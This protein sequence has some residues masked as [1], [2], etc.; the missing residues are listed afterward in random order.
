MLIK[1]ESQC[2]QFTANDGCSIRELVH[3][4][5]DGIDPGFS[6]AVAEVEV[7]HRTYRHRLR[8]A[9]VYYIVAGA[10]VVHV[11]GEERAVGVGDAV[12]IPPNETQWIRNTHSE[13]LKFVAI[14]APPWN[15]EDDERLDT[16]GIEPT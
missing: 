4:K 3:P 9:E 12:F 11:G 6:L 14:V 5:N 7:G 16:T 15:S 1:S 8:Q 2:R 10:G 13:L